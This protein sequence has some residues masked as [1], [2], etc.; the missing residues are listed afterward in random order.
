MSS[1]DPD[2]IIAAR[3][4]SPLVVGIGSNETIIAS[5][6]SAVLPHTRDVIYLEDFDLAVISKHSV[7]LQDIKNSPVKRKVTVIDWDVDD[8]EKGLF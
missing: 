4:G 1:C 2:K 8:I 6:A 3:C 7:D 5:D